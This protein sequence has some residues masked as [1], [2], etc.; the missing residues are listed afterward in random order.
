MSPPSEWFA[1]LLVAL[2]VGV[3][4][5]AGALL[6][7][8]GPREQMELMRESGPDTL[9]MISA[10]GFKGEIYFVRS[11]DGAML[12]MYRIVNP[13]ANPR[14]LNSLPVLMFHGLAGDTSQ[15]ISRS[16]RSK[17]RAPIP[18]Q[19]VAS[20]QLDDCLAF[21]LANNNFET[22]MVDARGTNLNNHHASADLDFKESQKVWNFTL[23]EEALLDLP[24]AIDFV[25]RQTGAPKLH[26]IGFSEST[27][28]V[29]ALM[30]S[31]PEYQLKFASVTALAPVAYVNHIRGTA[32]TSLM[33]TLSLPD[34]ISANIMPQTLVDSVGAYW[35]K[36]CEYQIAAHTVDRKSTR[37]NSSH[38]GESRMPSSA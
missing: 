4:P 26:Y 2:V 18:G 35:R 38:S 31:S 25:L 21:M 6:G 13:A 14:Q 28:F 27:F 12:S 20:K 32:L 8:Q 17:P 24:A 29:F 36:L 7:Q 11:R 33:F 16:T 9:N 34:E 37:L 22:F 3:G 10:R 30:A 1:L 23:N 19:M 15:M 5:L